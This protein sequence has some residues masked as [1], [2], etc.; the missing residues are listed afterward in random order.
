MKV[1]VKEL[2]NKLIS[3]HLP[4]DG[5]VNATKVGSLWSAGAIIAYRKG[6]CCTVKLNGATVGTASS[7]TTIASLPTNYRPPSEVTFPALPNTANRG[8]VGVRAT[9]EIWIESRTVADAVYANITYC[10]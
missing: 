5:E 9:G 4:P 7:R 2:T 10:V 6:N 8:L 1:D 3:M